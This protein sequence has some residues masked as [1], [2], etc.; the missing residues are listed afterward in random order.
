MWTFPPFLKDI[1]SNSNSPDYRNVHIKKTYAVSF[2]SMGAN[3]V[4]SIP[5]LGPYCFC[6][7]RQIN[8]IYTLKKVKN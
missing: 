5:G 2:A 6:V 1:M 4:E 7:Q 3:L 8:H